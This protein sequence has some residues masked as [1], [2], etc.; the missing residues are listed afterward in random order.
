MFKTMNRLRPI[1]LCSAALLLFG[2]NRNLPSV[3]QSVLAAWNPNL[4]ALACSNYDIAY[5]NVHGTR[6]AGINAWDASLITSPQE[7]V[8]SPA[9][10]FLFFQDRT[11][12]ALVIGNY[13]F[14]R[15]TTNFNLGDSSKDTH[16]T[17]VYAIKTDPQ[18]RIIDRK[19]LWVSHVSLAVDSRDRNRVFTP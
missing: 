4:T 16:Y 12:S 5:I 19:V 10:T 2:C 15:S 11:L 14:Q 18:Q 1:F 13:W 8:N 3:G 7:I 6:I 17:K 9:R